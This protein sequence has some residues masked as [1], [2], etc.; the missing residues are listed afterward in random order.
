MKVTRKVSMKRSAFVLAFV[1]RWLEALTLGVGAAWAG[2]FWCPA[3]QTL[4]P[5]P[6]RRTD[7]AP[8]TGRFWS[9]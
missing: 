7:V 4:V 2:N 3:G 8:L 6:V 9:R 1:A 5:V